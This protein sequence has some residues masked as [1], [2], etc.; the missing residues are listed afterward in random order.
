MFSFVC[1]MTG[2]LILCLW[3]PADN[4]AALLSFASFFG[5]F[6]GSYISL[7]PALVAEIGPP[8]EFGYRAGLLFACASIGGLVTNP[9][10]G[11]ILDAENGSF[12]GLKVFAGVFCM[13]GTCVTF[14]ARLSKTGLKLAVKF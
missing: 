1:L 10:A 3:I 12:T 2:I 11:A 9:I 5:F 4:N 14:A 6:S 7:S 8:Q 13:V